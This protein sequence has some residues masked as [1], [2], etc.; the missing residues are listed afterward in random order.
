MVKK[1]VHVTYH[2]VNIANVTYKT[3]NGDD[4]LILIY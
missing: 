4:D 1:G 2:K 3:N